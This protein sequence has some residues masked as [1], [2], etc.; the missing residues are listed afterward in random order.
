M[1]FGT[2]EISKLYPSFLPVAFSAKTTD[3][4]DFLGQYVGSVIP[5]GTVVSKA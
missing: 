5:L 2:R 3:L 1:G 4:I